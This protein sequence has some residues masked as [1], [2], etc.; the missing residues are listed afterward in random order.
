MELASWDPQEAKAQT[1]ETRTPSPCAMRALQE[2]NDSS[3]RSGDLNASTPPC[4]PAVSLAD[5]ENLTP[6]SNSWH[7]RQSKLL[8]DQG[9]DLAAA[10]QNRAMDEET[11]R[12]VVE[13]APAPNQSPSGKWYK[14][15]QVCSSLAMACVLA[16]SAQQHMRVSCAAKAMT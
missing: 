5:S 16:A 14:D 11:A 4:R 2:T 1:D 6:S 15:R 7:S 8:H 12:L 9:A 13:T 10:A 3:V